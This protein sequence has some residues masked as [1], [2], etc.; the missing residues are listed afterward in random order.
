MKGPDAS[1]HDLTVTL[2]QADLVWEDPVANRHRLE[3]KLAVLRGQTDLVVLPEMFTT[4]FTM[5]PEKNAEPEGATLQWMLEQARHMQATLTGSVA[6][7]SGGNYFN[8]LYWVQPDGVV[9]TYDKRHLFRMAGEQDHYQAGEAAL[10]IEWRGWRICPLVCYDLRFPV[11]SR[12]RAGLDYDLLL[13]VA[14]WPK[15]RRHPWQVLLKARAIENLSYCVGVNRFGVDGLGY[16]HSGD[17]A[18]LDFK[19]QP[20]LEA[21]EQEW[22][23]SVTLDHAALHEFRRKFPAHLDADG[24]SLP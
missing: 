3:Q 18:V 14:N 10:L 23:G 7:S 2:M 16:E 1:A 5:K 24:F 22:Q 17:S 20:L 11:W 15:V 19:G 13:Y 21:P 6:V 4:G 9:H 12:R 8:R